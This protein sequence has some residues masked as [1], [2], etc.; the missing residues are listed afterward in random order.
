MDRPTCVVHAWSVAGEKRP[1]LTKAEGVGALVRTLGDPTGLTRLGVHLREIQPGMAGS[2]RHWHVVEEEWGYVLSGRGAVRIGPHRIPVR[3]GS[4]VG[5]PPG[6]R[7]H[8]FLAEGDEPLVVLDGGERR[9]EEDHGYYPDLSMRFEVGKVSPLT[10]TLPPEEGDPGQCVHVD[11]VPLVPYQHDVDPLAR[12][13]YRRLSQHTGLVRQTVR[14][15]RVESGDLSTALHSHDRTDEWAFILEGRARAQSGELTFEV[16]PG[17]FIG[18]PAG[19]PAHQMEP[20]EPLTYLMGGGRDA[21]D[22]VTYPEAGYR[23][24]RGR[25]ESLT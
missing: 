19:G 15:T 18:C 10:E 7:P 17:D 13:V 23:R 21:D 2:N 3:A 8:H 9:P 4:F 14:W 5:F 12:R 24:V 20:I 22:V 11:D 1:R 16:G 25:L 6:P